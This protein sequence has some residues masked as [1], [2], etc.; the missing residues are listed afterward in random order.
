MALG[1]IRKCCSDNCL[2]VLPVSLDFSHKIMTI[3]FPTY[4]IATK[5]DIASNT[6]IPLAVIII[7]FPDVLHSNNEIDRFLH[8]LKLDTDIN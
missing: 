8:G 6:T 2:V 3:A 5:C 1:Y 7:V 4:A